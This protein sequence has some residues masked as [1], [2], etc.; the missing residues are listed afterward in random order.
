MMAAQTSRFLDNRD[1]VILS[2]PP[3][4]TCLQACVEDF[5]AMETAYSLLYCSGKVDT[6]RAYHKRINIA[7]KKL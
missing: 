4:V 1:F 5:A 6:K 7:I 3:V 2:S